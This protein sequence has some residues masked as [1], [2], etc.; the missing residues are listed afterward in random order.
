MAQRPPLVDAVWTEPRLGAVSIGASLPRVF[1]VLLRQKLI[2]PPLFLL[3]VATR[4]SSCCKGTM[5]EAVRAGKRA[6]AALR[7]RIGHALPRDF[8]AGMMGE[9]THE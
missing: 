5:R 4:R 7:Q 6:G 8:R 9:V 2:A 1:C 3:P